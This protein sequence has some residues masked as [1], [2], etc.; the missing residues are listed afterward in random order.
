MEELKVSQ[1][2]SE[3]KPLEPKKGL[4]WKAVVLVIILSLFFGIIGGG[5]GVILLLTKGGSFLRSYLGGDGTDVSIPTTVNEK[6]KLEESS[7]ITDTVDKVRPSVVSIV[8]V[9]KR[10][11]IFNIISTE[12]SAG[13]GF[14]VTS[15][16]LIMTN[17]HV[18]LDSGADYT[19]F[20]NDGKSYS[21][22]VKSLDPMNDLALIK[23]EAKNLTVAEFGS[24]DDLKI[25]QFVIAIG[26]ALGEFQNTVTLGVLSAKERMVEASSSDGTSTETFEGLLQ[27][28][29][30]INQGNSGGPLVNLE[31]QVVGINV[32]VAAEAEN[33]GFAIPVELARTAVESY[34]R[35][36]K[37]V[38][39]LIGVRYVSLTPEIAG[40]NNISVDYGAYVY[41]NS[42]TTPAV[43]PGSP[44]DNAGMKEGDIITAIGSD[45]IDA[46]H[47]LSRLIQKY[48]PGDE[49]EI[50]YLRGDD[51]DKITL[52][53][54]SID[55]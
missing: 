16:G 51:E 14:I 8:A 13:S 50:T 41:S 7:K 26:N 38:R 9:S 54:T 18:V 15:D 17:K 25:G 4:G 33:I 10:A 28:D 6:L 36:S 40:A 42:I 27:T 32:V 2:D 30:A 1:G 20:T 21:A 44:A 35:N 3:F 52:K 12:R 34:K 53:L 43:I 45:K 23:I 48:Q 22:E 47:S 49:V 19:V 46:S 37:I 39:P 31:G 24:S 5:G 29:A 55:S 11:G